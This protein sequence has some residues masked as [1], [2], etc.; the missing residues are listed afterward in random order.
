MSA[1]FMQ[2]RMASILADIVGNGNQFDIL[3]GTEPF[4]NPKARRPFMTINEYFRFHTSSL[5]YH[6]GCALTIC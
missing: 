6:M 3:A 2:A 5:L 4:M 1:C